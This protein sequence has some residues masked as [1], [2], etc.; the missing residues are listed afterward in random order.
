MLKPADSFPS[1][2]KEFRMESKSRILSQTFGVS[3][4][5]I[6]DIWN[7]RTWKSVTLKRNGADNVDSRANDK[8]QAIC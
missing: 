4:K 7:H 5:A 3:P 8:L 6:R 2:H 1:E